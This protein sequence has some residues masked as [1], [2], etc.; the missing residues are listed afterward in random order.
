[1]QYFARTLSF[2]AKGGG[3]PLLYKDLKE[4]QNALSDARKITKFASKPREL[5]NVRAAAVTVSKC[6]GQN[7]VGLGLADARVW[8]MAVVRSCW[9]RTTARG[10]GLRG[11]CSI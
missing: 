3:H 11:A 2:F 8:V 4:I 10:T 1:M 6:C 9:L 5:H 7:M